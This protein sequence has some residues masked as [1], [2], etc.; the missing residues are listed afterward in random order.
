MNFL[1]KNY[2]I[3][4]FS[5]VILLTLVGFCFIMFHKNETKCEFITVKNDYYLVNSDKENNLNVPLFISLKDSIFVDLEEINNTSLVTDNETEV[6]PLT[7][8]SLTYLDEVNYDDK[9]FYEYD[10]NFCLD[11]V[12]DSLTIYD[13]IYLKILYKS[14]A[15][16]KIL[17]GSITL[18]NYS[19]N[20]EV[21]YTNLKGVTSKHN[22]N[23]ILSNVL[24]KFNT[25]NQIE[26]V[27][28]KTL[29]SKVSVDLEYS[30]VIDYIDENSTPIMDFINQD[31]KIIGSSN[32]KKS[33]L[34]NDKDYLLIYLKYDKY[35][36]LPCQGFVISY[37]DNGI[38]C[39]KVISPFKFFK[40]NNLN[41]EI[42]RV[43]YEKNID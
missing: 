38:L 4:I 39:E 5:I 21:F 18:Y 34:I 31:Y 23:M 12:F 29:N 14:G 16:I 33:I 15:S 9:T 35:I 40:S 25:Q 30:E 6:L 36:E 28:I 11:M 42:I 17:L 22:N 20:E 8:N 3:I 41:G 19:L 24:V 2:K 13:Q 32:F 10:L 27:D 1:K 7:I 26:I 37:L 43:E